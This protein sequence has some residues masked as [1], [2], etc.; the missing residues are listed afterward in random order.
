[1]PPAFPP[2]PGLGQTLPEEVGQEEVPHVVDPQLALNTLRRHRPPALHQPGVIDQNI[3]LALLGLELL[4]EL[5]DGLLARQVTL[6]K[7][8]IG[9]DNEVEGSTCSRRIYS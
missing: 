7:R 5:L 2:G 3:A 6:S 8:I 4:H 9:E 1:M